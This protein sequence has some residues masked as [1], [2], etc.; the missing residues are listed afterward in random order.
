M[1]PDISDDE[2]RVQYFL[3]MRVLNAETGDILW[4]NKVSVTKALL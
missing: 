3:F 2:R 1:I 4:Q